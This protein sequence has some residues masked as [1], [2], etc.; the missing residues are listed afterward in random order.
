MT[1]RWVGVPVATL[2][3]AGLALLLISLLTVALSV[4]SRRS[5]EAIRWTEHTRQVLALLSQARESLAMAE[6]SQRGYLLDQQPFYLG[7][8]QTAL[9][10]LK[11]TTDASHHLMDDLPQQLALSAEM[12][13]LTAE[14]L[15]IF[16]S[17][18]QAHA[19]GRKSGRDFFSS[20]VPQEASDR[21]LAVID[22]L[23]TEESRLLEERLQT[24]QESYAETR[25]I[26]IAIGGIGVCLLV[27]LMLT[28]LLQ[29]RALRRSEVRLRG[30]AESLPGAVYVYRMGPDGTARYEF[31]SRNVELIRGVNRDE[32]MR[33][34]ELANEAV[35]EEDRERFSQAV[36]ESRRALTDLEVDFRIRRDD[37]IRWVRS[38]AIPSRLYDG[39]VVWNGYWSDVTAIK[40]IESSLQE[41]RQRLEDAQRVARLGD[42]TH[43]L[44]SG[45]ITWSPFLYELFGRDLALGP[46]DL[47][48]AVTLF[49]AGSTEVIAAAID[50]VVNSG[51]T[52]QYELR[53]RNAN[54]DARHFLVTCVAWKWT[55]GRVTALRGTLQ[56]ITRRKLSESRL[57]E[58]KE[59]AEAANRAKSTFLATMSHE[60]RT[61][62]NGILG[63]LELIS[64]RP[65]EEEVR[66]ALEV[67]RES[68]ASLQRIID[69]ILDF[70]KI[71]AG[72]LV[73]RAEP[74]SIAGIV[75]SVQQIFSGTASS[76]GLALTQTCDERLRQPVMI[77]GQRLRQILSN[78]VS[79]S[80]K[81]TRSGQISIRAELEESGVAGPRARITV[82]DSGIGI[83]AEDQSHLFE[84]FTQ[85]EGNSP[86]RF[87]G[88][89]LGLAICRRLAE[90]M[91]GDIQ[92]QSTP[93]V[94]TRITLRLPTPVAD[95]PLLQDAAPAKDGHL[96]NGR[97][98]VPARA[99]PSVEQAE[100]EGTLVLVVDD[101]PINLMVIR[102]Q[103]NVLGY[104]TLEAE[105]A[106]QAL[107]MLRSRRFGLLLT[108]C[109][110]PDMSGYE[111]SQQVR[112]EER[113]SGAQRMPI[114]A[115]SANA[116]DGVALRCMAAGMDDYLV[117]PASLLLMQ[118][119]LARWLPLPTPL[120]AAHVPV[121]ALPAAANTSH[122]DASP[123]PRQVVDPDVLQ[124]LARGDAAV[125]ERILRQFRCQNEA[126]TAA[127]RKAIADGD[128]PQTAHYAHRIKGAAG[129][130]GAYRLAETCNQLEQAGRNDD[131][132][133]IAQYWPRL[134]VDQESLDVYLDARQT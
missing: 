123:K 85:A 87:G 133:A 47:A 120:D 10:V 64:L 61:P 2:L 96:A 18:M 84:P 79:N 69:D 102:G 128:H 29:S 50:E 92:L 80:L 42:W 45:A 62:M 24:Q 13:V 28:L 38:S 115:C 65:L 6:S 40:D 15:R 91:G 70:S 54:R 125:C 108:D 31:L 106:P 17:V 25:H 130:I 60:I 117:K 43:D 131:A 72:K 126:D 114:I 112:E 41:A 67:A 93:G 122:V 33:D 81:F 100:A 22:R 103:L 39:S 119:R 1:R 20:G 27:P 14:R 97:L 51:E 107:A 52:C 63:T 127:L 73:I 5:D 109:N 30:I 49:E 11:E 26:L 66:R 89:G 82:E 124:A 59:A 121:N 77:D 35:L 21:L 95:L 74:T 118:E 44:A 86:A 9:A 132:E 55:E 46:P 19:Q 58:A 76:I 34:A 36:A 129:L 94:G 116:L 53:Q 12:Q 68:G 99:T 4:S 71:E 111:L 98:I 104:A 83:S 90:L 32:I 113:V 8:L 78:L 88:T 23:A 105:G 101:H 56:D 16:D 75:R 37:G 48:E 110:M 134:H 57:L 7:R 3:G